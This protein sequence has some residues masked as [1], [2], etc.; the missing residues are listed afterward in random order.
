MKIQHSMGKKR[1]GMAL[2]LSLIVLLV[3]GAMVT[4]SLYFIENMAT[5]TR[6]KTDRELRM[7]AALAGLEDGKQWILDEISAGRTPKLS[8]ADI[9]AVKTIDDVD[10]LLGKLR[11]KS[12]SFTNQGIAGTVEIFDLV[13]EPSADLKFDQ[14][15]PPRISV[16][17]PSIWEESSLVQRQ[18]YDSSNRG[19]GTAEDFAT[20]S[21]R[22]R[23][24]LIRSSVK[25][26]EI[27]QTVEQAVLMKRW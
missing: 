25:Y 16:F 27:D 15:I 17:F 26:K 24:Y 22:Y 10:D 14:G 18:S 23:A 6:M 2:A 19:E 5:T 7:N 12:L 9:E 8:S 20:Q 13:Y 1:T 3:A 21:A 4:V 11:Q